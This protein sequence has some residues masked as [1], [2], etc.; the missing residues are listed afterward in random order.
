MEAG[1]R[2]SHLPHMRL[3]LRLL[4]FAAFLG[5]CPALQALDRPELTFQVYQF[6]RDAIPRIDGDASD[7]SQVPESYAIGKDRLEDD[8]KKN[9]DLNLKSLDVRVKVGWV[10]G[11][12]RLYFLYEATDD[13][14]RFGSTTLANDTF[15]LMVDGDASGG[16]FIDR[17][18][19][20]L[21]VPEEVGEAAAKEDPRVPDSAQHWS[22]HGVHAQNYH[23]FTPSL[24]KAWAMAWGSPTWVKEF[25]FANAAERYDFKPGEG[26]RYTLE[27]WITPF[28]YAGP[29][30][31]ER[32]VESKLWENKIVGLS[33]M[34]IDYDGP[35]D[36]RSG[37]WR[38]SSHRLAL[39]N[40]SRLCAFRLMPLEPDLVPKPK[41]QWNWTT[42]DASSRTVAFKDLSEG[43]IEAW[44]WDFGDGTSST[45]RNPVHR[46][47]QMPKGAIVL[48]VTG[49]QGSARMAKLMEVSFP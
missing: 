18:Q 25:P 41:A 7:W 32:S 23:I 19:K 36:R 10:K 16:P 43:K 20:R 49:P 37:F 44:K 1:R 13:D 28:D 9:A 12:N 40:A 8:S 35:N 22:M 26:G 5:S 47:E 4:S 30:G 2:L 39:A 33:W 42:L 24:N 31:P 29:E 46:F 3:P 27:F 48:E 6:P 11:L 17:E 38:L 34:I 21:W 15:E 45:E 14:W